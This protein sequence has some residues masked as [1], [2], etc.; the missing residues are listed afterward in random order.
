MMIL[1]ENWQQHW[2]GKDPFECVLA[3]QGD[4]YRKMDGRRTLRFDMLGKSYFAKVYRGVGWARILKSVLSLRQPPVLDAKNEWLAIQ[5]LTELGVATMT[6]VGYGTRGNSPASK[7][8]FLIT[9][10]LQQTVSLED[11]CR[12]WQKN[13]P[14]LRFKRTLIKKIAQV[15]RTLHDNGINHRDYYLCHFLLDI[16]AGK[17]NLFENVSCDN[18]TPYL[19][20]LHRV[21]FRQNVPQRWLVKDLASLY[22]SAMEIGLTQ[23]DL[24]RFIAEYTQQPLRKAVAESLWNKVSRRAVYLQQRFYRKYVS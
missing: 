22:F 21:Q 12:D 24:Y 7:Q 2:Q 1:P 6:I 10:D 9:E 14:N 23:R 17:E 4:E 16:S 13:S 8:S 19:I 3:L 18:I 11:F 5:K 20:D 15:S